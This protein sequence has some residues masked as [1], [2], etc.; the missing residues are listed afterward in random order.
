L[1]GCAALFAIVFAIA[2]SLS[3]NPLPSDAELT[4]HF[5]AHRKEIEQLVK[6]FREVPWPPQ[7]SP[8]WDDLPEVRALKER[9]GIRRVVE[10]NAVWLEDPYSAGTAKKLEEV[11]RS[12][13]QRYFAL[14][15]Q[16]GSIEVKLADPH[17]GP[18]F[19]IVRLSPATVWK[20]LYYFP[21]APRVSDGRVWWPTRPD[22]LTAGSPVLDQLDS[23]PKSWGKG[24][25]VFR[26]VEDQ[27][28]IRMCWGAV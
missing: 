3:F 24:E 18:R 23:Y 19:A 12:D 20:E 9:A 25:C 5:G 4:S 21:Q 17:Y 16:F 2:A 26:R 7:V 22:G 10:S 28:F 13:G 11:A 8:Q 27:W 6:Q 14:K 1:I 15:R